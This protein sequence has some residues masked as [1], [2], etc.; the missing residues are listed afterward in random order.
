M[1]NSTN[2]TSFNTTNIININWDINEHFYIP[3]YLVGLLLLIFINI[4]PYMYFKFVKN[5]KI[6]NFSGFEPKHT[7]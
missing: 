5:K 3:G 1:E 7:I 4:G 6:F 2:I